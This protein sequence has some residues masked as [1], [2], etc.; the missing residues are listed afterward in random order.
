MGTPQYMSPEQISAPGE[1]DHRADI[2]ALGVVFYQMLTGELPGKPIQPPSTKVHIDVRLDRIV[3]RALEKSPELRYQQA[4][5]LKT[6]VETVAATLPAST[7][8]PQEARAQKARPRQDWWTWSPLQSPEVGEICAHLA[9]AER[10]VLSILGLL[11]GVWIV[12]TIFGI[13]TLIRSFPS[14]GNWVVASIWGILFG[15]SIPM[16]HRMARHF[17]CS[18]AWAKEHGFTPEMLRL[19]SLRRGNIWKLAAV[20]AG[21][22]ALALVQDKAITSYLGLE[23]RPQPNKAQ[24]PGAVVT[25]R[26]SAAHKGDFGV[27]LGYLGTVESSNSVTFQISEDYVQ[28]V[29]KKFDARQPITI[30]AY[31][32]QGAKFGHGSLTGLDGRID[33]ATGT[34]KCRANL[35][36]ERDRLMVPGL[37][38]NIRM[39]LETNH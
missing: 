38:L 19:F 15:V 34:L 13:P 11:S 31:D 12:G 6:Q 30:E 7:S 36:P 2:Y 18:T 4:S 23:G 20:L 9:K 8:R 33:T 28:E 16:I 17:L 35:I 3:L 22:L 5:A 39:L 24:T 10:N 32:R 29:M 26:A 1:V 25:I 37:F 21:G 14:P 27:Y